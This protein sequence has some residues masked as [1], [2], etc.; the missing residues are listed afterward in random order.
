MRVLPARRVVVLGLVGLAILLIVAPLTGWPSDDGAPT[1][2]AAV[3]A[4]K[5]ETAEAAVPTTSSHDGA[6]QLAA[7]QG[8]HPS[9]TAGLDNPC[10]ARFLHPAMAAQ[11]GLEVADDADCEPVSAR[12]RAT[13][14]SALR[15]LGTAYAWGGGDLHGPTRGTD[16][17]SMVVGFD[18]SGLTRYALGNAGLSIPRNSRQQWNAPGERITTMA[19]LRPGDLVFFAKDTSDPSTIYHVG[20]WA[21]EDAMIEAPYADGWVRVV[22][23]MSESP[24]RAPMF[25]GGLR[26]DDGSGV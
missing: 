23:N 10:I 24:D 20:L 13:L 12:M 18:C 15:W 16:S 3:A 17:G 8:W 7:S 26:V 5:S 14:V 6:T 1:P 11:A 22:P 25:I 9:V 4:S 2:R 19:D 21:G